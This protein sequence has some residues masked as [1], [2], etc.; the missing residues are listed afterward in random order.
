MDLYPERC[1]AM[2]E[3][4]RL[5]RL[6]SV[7]H[8]PAICPLC[9]KPF[10]LDETAVLIYYDGGLLGTI[11]PTC[12]KCAP[13]RAAFR[14]GQRVERLRQAVDVELAFAGTREMTVMTAMKTR[15]ERWVTLAEELWKLDAWPTIRYVR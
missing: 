8:E 2:L 4:V 7:L 3:R 11:C 9:E 13:S 14:V 10:N 15:A 12:L 5:E 6:P 1:A